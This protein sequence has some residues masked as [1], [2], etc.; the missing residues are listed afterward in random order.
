[1]IVQE[2]GKVTDRIT[3]LG[4]KES[5]VYHLDC[6]DEAVI[7]G[8]GM[9]QIVPEVD[10]QIS[11]FGLDPQKIKRIIILHSHF[12]HCGIV[13]FFTGKWPHVSVAASEPAKAMLVKQKVVDTIHAMNR[14]ALE[15]Y[16]MLEKAEEMGFADFTGI[17]VHEVLKEGLSIGCGDRTLEILEVP[18]HS[19]CSIAVYVPGEKAMFASDA[20]GIALG[21]DV[22]TA[23][24]SDFDKYQQSLEKMAA[25]DVDVCLSEH[26]GARTGQDGRNF[27]PRSKQA[28]AE[29]RER[30]EQSLERT[31]DP[32]KT[33]DEISGD[34]IARSPQDFLPKEI[35]SMIIRQMAGNLYKKQ[36][37]S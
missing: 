25:Y 23:A 28:A 17:G 26:Y 33:A 7:L 10:E 9:V 36:A 18:G 21:D 34:V 22:F 37:G 13:P 4:R 3:L 27:L 16:N 35:I 5:N 8:G 15:R 2:P 12:D 24:N 32:D 19:S 30:I 1:M 14:A 29:F 6:G 20:G 11:R 31:N